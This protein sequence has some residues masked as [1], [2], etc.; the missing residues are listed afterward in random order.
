MKT[1]FSF[2]TATAL[3]VPVAYAEIS[4]ISPAD[5]KALIENADASKRP[6]VLDTRGGYKDYFRGHLPTAHHI[7]FDT[8]R[9]TNEGVP[10]WCRAEYQN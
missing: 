7:N 8:R 3:L 4:L 6:I 5:A 9:G 10:H 2:L 1:I